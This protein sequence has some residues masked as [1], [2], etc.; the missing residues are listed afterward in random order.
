MNK[1]YSVI[2]LTLLLPVAI[3]LSISMVV[4]CQSLDE[5]K[6]EMKR[7]WITR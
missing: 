3:L 2:R 7:L 5:Y 1:L 4:A 6:Q